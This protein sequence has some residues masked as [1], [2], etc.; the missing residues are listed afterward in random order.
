[1]PFARE[2]LINHSIF[3]SILRPFGIIH[4]LNTALYLPSYRFVLE[5]AG[6][7]SANSPEPE[8]VNLFRSPGSIPSRAG[9]VDN[10]I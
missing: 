5:D 7:E 3:F 4:L 1:M 2:G 8:F 6:I 10:P 9:R